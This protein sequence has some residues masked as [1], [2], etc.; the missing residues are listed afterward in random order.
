MQR[1]LQQ[2]TR[3]VERQTRQARVERAGITVPEVAEEIRLTT[4]S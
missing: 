1:K 3:L 4:H 2:R